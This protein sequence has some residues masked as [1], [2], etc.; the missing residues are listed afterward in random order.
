MNI[1]NYDIKNTR[2]N[3]KV[4]KNQLELV[5]DRGFNIDEADGFFLDYNFN[6]YY[7]Y[8]MNTAYKN[9]ST[10]ES[11]LSYLYHD[12]EK[13]KSIY[14]YYAPYIKNITKINKNIAVEFRQL[15]TKLNA[16]EA[17]LITPLQ[18]KPKSSDIKNTDKKEYKYK[19]LSSDAK[20]EIKLLEKTI[21]IQIFNVSELLINPTKHTYS[22]FME[23]I[24]DEFVDNKLTELNCTKKDLTLLTSNDPIVRWYGWNIG[25]MI[26]IHRNDDDIPLTSTKTFG[27]RLIID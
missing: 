2:N 21:K 3:F 6:Q 11:I 16:T 5:A 13:N 24:P 27:Y 17:I 19:S 20:K 18:Y 14:V 23:K 4:K 8:L 15:V 12:N 25:D 9:K 26:K 7:D 1:N 10:E 22:R